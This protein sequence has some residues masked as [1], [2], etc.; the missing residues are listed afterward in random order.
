M[1]RSGVL[2]FLVACVV[3]LCVLSVV[4]LVSRQIHQRECEE[5]RRHVRRNYS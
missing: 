5:M 2:I 3:V 4:R 1:S